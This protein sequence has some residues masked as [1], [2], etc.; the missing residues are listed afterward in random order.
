MQISQNR[1]SVQQAGQGT[2][3][4]QVNVSIDVTQW[5]VGYVL[6][7]EASLG[8]GGRRGE[9]QCGVAC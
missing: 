1:A 9:E 2:N 3:G 7:G 6:V 5:D 8:E 4:I